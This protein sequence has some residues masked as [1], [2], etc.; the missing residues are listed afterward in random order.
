[1]V[2]QRYTP[3]IIARAEAVVGKIHGVSSCRISTDD[4]GEISE[5]HVVA[6][7]KKPAKLIARDVETCLMAEMG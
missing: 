1:M 2:A 5:V 6:T 7:A 3:D 4:A